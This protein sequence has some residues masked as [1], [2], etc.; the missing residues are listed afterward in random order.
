MTPDEK[1]WS[2]VNKTETCWLWTRGLVYGYGQFH[3]TIDGKKYHRAHRYAYEATV[4][5]I[6]TGLVLDHICRVRNCVRP[7]HLRAVTDRENT[8]EPR[9]ESPSRKNAEKTHCSHGHPLS[10]E[11]LIMRADRCKHPDR[12][13][14]ECRICRTN[15]QAAYDAKNPGHKDLSKKHFCRACERKH[16]SKE[17]DFHGTVPSARGPV[18]RL[19]TCRAAR[20]EQL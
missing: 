6:P 7:D 13:F 12:R 20:G 9:S 1:F 19:W 17:W 15:T 2:K 16:C 3:A 11:N 4:G 8:L 10:G 18:K 14:R 5:P